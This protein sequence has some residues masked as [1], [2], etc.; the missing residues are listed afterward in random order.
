MSGFAYRAGVVSAVCLMAPFM[1]RLASEVAA[2]RPRAARALTIFALCVGAA[3]ALAMIFPDQNSDAFY[4]HDAAAVAFAVC[5]PIVSVG[6][7]ASMLPDASPFQWLT[8]GVVAICAGLVL[9]VAVPLLRRYSLLTLVVALSDMARSERVPV[10]NGIVEVAW[11]FPMS[12]SALIVS[13]HL[14]YLATALMMLKRE[15]RAGA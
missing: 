6:F 12:E 4:V 8:S 7:T 9:A 1:A 13:T 14:W 11:W 5:Q 15:R 3:A 2:R 10:L